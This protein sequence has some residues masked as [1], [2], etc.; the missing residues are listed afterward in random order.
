[1][2]GYHQAQD[3]MSQVGCNIINLN[4]NKQAI[5]SWK[6]YQTEPVTS[7]GKSEAYGLFCGYSDI[8]VIDSSYNYLIRHYQNKR[9]Y[10]KALEASEKARDYRRYGVL[11]RK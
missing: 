6:Q 9:M 11:K 3:I 10:K 8:E 7:L 4:N 5:R 2:L 1:M